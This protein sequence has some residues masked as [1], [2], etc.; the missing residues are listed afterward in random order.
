M[1]QVLDLVADGLQPVLL[2]L[3][4]VEEDP[5]HEHLRVLHLLQLPGQQ[6]G[7]VGGGNVVFL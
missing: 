2:V 5:G 1:L 6:P 3:P 7:Q 4:G